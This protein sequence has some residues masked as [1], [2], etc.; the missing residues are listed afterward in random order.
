MLG[1]LKHIF[2]LGAMVLASPVSAQDIPLFSSLNTDPLDAAFQAPLSH[3]ET[4]LLNAPEASRLYLEHWITRYNA[5]VLSDRKL[6]W[7]KSFEFGEIEPRTSKAN[8]AWQPNGYPIVSP[9][10]GLKTPFTFDR[11]DR[12]RPSPPL[13]MGDAGYDAALSDVLIYGDLHSEVRTPDQSLISAFW[14]NG[15]GTGTSPGQWNLIG[16]N[17]TSHL[18]PETRTE[19]MLVL[20]IA[21]YD[22]GIAAWDAK[23]HYQYWRP[24]TAITASDLE[25]AEWEP[26]MQPPFHPEYVSGHS[27]FS[28]AASTVLQYFLGNIDFCVVAPELSDLE[29]CYEGFEAAAEEAGRSRIFGG[30]HFEFS[31]QAGLKLGREVA[32]H[33]ISTV[34]LSVD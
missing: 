23:Y 4:H 19:I 18:P 28:G 27:A 20:N 9:N 30:I 10:W 7:P 16:L 2:V 32:E 14:A 1:L 29:R 11:P 34:K 24:Q 26:M 12:F 5:S 31:N 33:V 17:V 21:L 6:S 8:Y 13:R 25:Y 15:P 22:A 3:V